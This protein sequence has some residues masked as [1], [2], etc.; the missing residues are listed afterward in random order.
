MKTLLNV[1]HEITMN[2]TKQ[3]FIKAM[4]PT[5]NH[6]LFHECFMISKP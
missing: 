2:F 6:G 5:K 4:K 3:G 1:C